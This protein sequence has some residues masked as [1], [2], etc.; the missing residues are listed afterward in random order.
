MSASAPEKKD[1][2][3]FD[4][5]LFHGPTEDGEGAR[6]LRARPGRL[7]AGEVRPMRDGRPLAG[8]GEVVRLQP[9]ADAP[10]LYDVAV[11]Y[12]VPSS[13]GG[14][15]SGARTGGGATA[16][17]AGPAG[18]AGAA[19]AT[20]SA[21][22]RAHAQSGPAQVATRAYRDNW[23]LTFGRRRKELN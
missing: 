16:G 19:G 13:V 20:A 14:S 18:A 2:D 3:A 21:G 7:D 1:G 8:G 17:A 10:S 11:E 6:V 5:V 22:E 12:A 9:R 23:E 4:V 15:S